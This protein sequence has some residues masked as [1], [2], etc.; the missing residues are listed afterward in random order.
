MEFQSH[1][2]VTSE[3]INKKFVATTP[4]L[5]CLQTSKCST[6]LKQLWVGGGR[7]GGSNPQS[8]LLTRAKIRQQWHWCTVSIRHITLLF[9]DEI[10]KNLL[11]NC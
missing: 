7:G 6:L 3:S 4:L 5:L 8:L 1:I 9:I 11:E 2:V 10:F